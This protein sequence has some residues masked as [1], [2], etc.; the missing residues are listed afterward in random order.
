MLFGKS[1]VEDVLSLHTLH[2]DTNGASSTFQGSYLLLPMEGA[3]KQE[4]K[5]SIKIATVATAATSEK[6]GGCRHSYV[7]QKHICS[8]T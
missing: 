6:G 3:F 2:S 1:W 4:W 7:S 8:F 5:I